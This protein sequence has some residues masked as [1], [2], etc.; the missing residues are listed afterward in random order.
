[1]NTT[2]E[3]IRCTLATNDEI[4]ININSISVVFEEERADKSKITAIFRNG[5]DTPII[6]RESVD[7]VLTMIQIR[8]RG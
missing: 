1:M 5:S 4:Y 2:P 7:Q 6:V 3:F 8:K